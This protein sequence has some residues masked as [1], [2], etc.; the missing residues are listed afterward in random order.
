MK[1]SA[2][3]SGE[4]SSSPRKG[5]N[6]GLPIMDFI[7]RVFAAVT[8]LASALS[9]GTAKQTMPFATRFFRFRVV[10]HDLPTFV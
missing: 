4:V 2:I 5:M 10:Y 9:M 8:T 6:R 7:L 3:E 1:I